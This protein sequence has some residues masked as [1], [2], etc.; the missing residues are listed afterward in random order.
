MLVRIEY[1]IATWKDLRFIMI[2]ILKSALSKE[3]LPPEKI[4]K[5]YKQLRIQV[6][7]SIFVGYAGYYFIRKNYNMAMPYM[8]EEYGYS[9]TQLGLIGA[10]IGLAYGLS[11]FVMGA[12]CDRSN[13]RYFMAA[14]LIFS[15]IVNLMFGFAS[16]VALLFV[17]MFLN[18]WFQGMG[19]PV[20]AK[21]MAHWFSSNERGFKLSIWNVSHNMG[22]AL[23][24]TLALFGMS[25]FNNWRGMFYFPA[26]IS[27]LIGVLVAIFLRDTPK[28]EGLPEIDDYRNDH[29]FGN[30]MTKVNVEQLSTKELL[31]KYVLNNKYI[32]FMASASGFVYLVRYGV[33]DWFPLYLKEHK[34]YNIEEAGAAFALSEWLAI[35]GTI[36]VGW[37]SDKLFKGRRA[38]MCIICMCGVAIAILVYWLSNSKIAINVAVASIGFLIYGPLMLIGVAAIDYVPKEA[39]GATGGF[40]GLF[41]YLFGTVSANLLVGAIVDVVG[42]NGSFVLLLASCMLAILLFMLT[43]NASS[44]IGIKV[45]SDI[46]RESGA[47]SS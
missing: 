10:A 33:L 32:W 17:L 1:V 42:W 11:K 43:W 39:A 16:S 20:C 9:I 25:I 41:G 14:G 22:A 23:G 45:E 29:S 27:I 6:F 8:S 13:P 2:G 35:P 31:F 26:L 15:G 12:L 18:G 5:T 36:L 30:S 37:L 7:M 3:C 44:H 28:S 34:A 38:P 21:I 19:N 47:L 46:E 4:D 24:P 40:V